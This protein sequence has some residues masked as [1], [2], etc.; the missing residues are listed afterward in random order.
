MGNKQLQKIESDFLNIYPDLMDSYE[1]VAKIC[2]TKC[3]KFLKENGIKAIPSYRVKSLDNL[4]K[5]L[6]SRTN[7]GRV[8][9]S[10]NDIFEQI[11]D[12]AGVRIAF[13]FPSDEEKISELIRKNFNVVL[14]KPHPDPTEQRGEKQYKSEYRATHFRVNI[15]T[16]ELES[17]QLDKGYNNKIIEIQVATVLMHAWSEVE[18]DLGYKPLSGKLSD[19]ET[20]SLNQLNALITASEL[21]LKQLERGSQARTLYTKDRFNDQYDLASYIFVKLKE[22]FGEIPKDFFMGSVEELLDFLRLSG[23]DSPQKVAEFIEGIKTTNT[24]GMSI[25]ELITQEIISKDATLTSK[26]TEARQGAGRWLLEEIPPSSIIKASSLP[27]LYWYGKDKK[28]Y[29][30]PTIHTFLT[31]FPSTEKMPNIRQL[32]DEVVVRIPIGGNITYRPG[33]KN[34]KIASSSYK[35]AVSH[36]GVL[37]LIGDPKIAVRIFGENWEDKVDTIPDAFFTN[38]FVGE[39]IKKV[40]DFDP[41]KER[42]MSPTID[43][44]KNLI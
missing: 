10:F 16:K 40:S 7:E 6:I 33:T 43:H 21:S 18:H 14:E 4:R 17:E 27:M 38:Y 19:Q 13:Y 39:E 1:V 15:K 9:N 34:I 35:Y 42:D 37:H 31:W 5:K 11:A 29:P 2:L 22:S 23:N 20:E 25:A 41:A 32:P 28:R 12:L 44:D 8:C 24:M 3:E 26:Y 36:G 30:I